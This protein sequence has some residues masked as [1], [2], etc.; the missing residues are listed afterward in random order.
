MA[1]GEI[2]IEFQGP[3]A[4][5]FRLVQ[6]HVRRVEFE[7]AS[8]TRERK[9]GM[10][11]REGGISSDR[12]DEVIARLFQKSRLPGRAQAV[13]AHEFRIRQRVSA[14]TWAF[15]GYRGTQRA[16]QRGRD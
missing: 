6:P 4:M 5:E 3:L 13:T 11:K 9:R 1:F 14:M 8:G 2:G 10:G 15:L 12:I 16:V 7:M